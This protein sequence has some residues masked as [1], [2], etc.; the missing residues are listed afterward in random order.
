MSI[1]EWF[2]LVLEC[3]LKEKKTKMCAYWLGQNPD[4]MRKAW[5]GEKNTIQ[6]IKLE[7]WGRSQDGQKLTD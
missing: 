3:L 7:Q 5:E 1:V 2:Y 6:R 4:T